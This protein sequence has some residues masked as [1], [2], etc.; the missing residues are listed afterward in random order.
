MP[1]TARADR[2]ISA[3]SACLILQI[4]PLLRRDECSCVRTRSVCVC[5]RVCVNLMRADG[6]PPRLVRADMRADS[7][8][9][10]MCPVPSAGAAEPTAATGTWLLVASGSE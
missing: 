3:G 9:S 7:A 8:A 5:V 1:H 6:L 10:V 4:R 2:L